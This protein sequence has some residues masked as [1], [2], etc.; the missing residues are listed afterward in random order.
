MV[1]YSLSLREVKLRQLGFKI[2]LFLKYFIV[3]KIDSF[4]DS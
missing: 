3:F 4:K 2:V 1:K